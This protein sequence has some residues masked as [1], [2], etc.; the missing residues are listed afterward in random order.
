M[1]FATPRLV[2]SLFLL[3]PVPVGLARGKTRSHFVSMGIDR[4]TEGQLK[5]VSCFGISV[6]EYLQQHGTV[7]RTEH[8]IESWGGRGRCVQYGRKKGL[9][10]HLVDVQG[11]HATTLDL[12][13]KPGFLG[14]AWLQVRLVPGGLHI[15]SP[16]CKSLHKFVNARRTKRSQLSPDGDES[17]EPVRIGNVFA[18][19][20]AWMLAMAVLRDVH[21]L[22]ETPDGSLLYQISHLVPVIGLLRNIGRAWEQLTYGCQFSTRKRIPQKKYRLFATHSWVCLL[23]RHCNCAADRHIKLMEINS[24]GGVVP[25]SCK[26]PRV[27]TNARKTNMRES[28]VYSYGFARA[29]VDAWLSHVAHA[30]PNWLSPDSDDN[31]SVCDTLSS[32]SSVMSDDDS[33]PG[34]AHSSPANRP[35]SEFWMRVSDEDQNDHETQNEMSNTSASASK[36]ASWMNVCDDG[37]GD[38]VADVSRAGSPTDNSWMMVND[39]ED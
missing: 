5:A 20:V 38:E 31:V 37:D 7:E 32:S 14:L 22:V 11:H 6:G 27:C 30:L 8:L 21:C 18:Q 28:Q 9:S 2:Y 17:Y 3:V 25:T 15:L 4:D 19:V 13:T 26:R 35:S 39:D 36:T 34:E 24:R 12:G 29:I 1:R 10:A 16:E 33:L 23:K